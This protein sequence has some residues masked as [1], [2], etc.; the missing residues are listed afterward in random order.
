MKT[1]EHSTAR[2]GSSTITVLFHFTQ[3]QSSSSDVFCTSGLDLSFDDN[4]NGD[5]GSKSKSVNQCT[6]VAQQCHFL[7]ALNLNLNV[8]HH[9]H[10]QVLNDY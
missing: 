5:A 1:Y 6:L 2:Q 4:D 7:V 8:S 3:N 10:E 9:D